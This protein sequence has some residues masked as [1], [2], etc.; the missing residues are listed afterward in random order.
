MKKQDDLF[1]IKSLTKSL[2]GNN[3]RILRELNFNGWQP[4]KK[5]T[6][7]DSRRRFTENQQKHILSQQNGRCAICKERLDPLITEYDHI[8]PWADKGKTIIENGA[9]LCRNCHGKKTSKEQ[10]KKT[11]RPRKEKPRKQGLGWQF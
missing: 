7:R 5:Q 4:P 1:G 6:K 8:R 10:L 3:K 2:E 9:A 11:E